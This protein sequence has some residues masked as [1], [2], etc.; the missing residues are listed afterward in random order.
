[1]SC[2]GV[3]VMTEDE[4]MHEELDEET[5]RAHNMLYQK[6][7]EEAI[8]A[9]QMLHQKKMEEDEGMDLEFDL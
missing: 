2:I 6:L 3:R 5:I 7:H 9:N 4:D 8:E 1:M